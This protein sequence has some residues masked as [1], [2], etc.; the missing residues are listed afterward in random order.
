MVGLY[1]QI[2]FFRCSLHSEGFV[3][4]DGSRESA[5]EFLKMFQGKFD[6]FSGMR[7]DVQPNRNRLQSRTLGSTFS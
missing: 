3:M 5:K 2:V 6:F 4:E 1:R 7:I